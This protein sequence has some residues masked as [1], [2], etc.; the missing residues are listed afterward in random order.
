MQV[1]VVF[2]DEFR[3]F[4]EVL[5]AHGTNAVS[6]DTGGDIDAVKDVADVVQDAGGDFSLAGGSRSVHQL[7]MDALDFHLH[8]FAFFDFIFE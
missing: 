6:G 5:D 1:L 8:A 2:A 4:A 3:C 7:S